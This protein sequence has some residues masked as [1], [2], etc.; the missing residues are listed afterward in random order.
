MN[1]LQTIWSVL[2]TPNMQMANY[3]SAPLILV[4]AYVTMLLFTSLLNIETN[5][6]KRLFYVLFISLI[7]LCLKFFIPSPYSTILN[8]ILIPIIIKLIFKTIFYFKY[9]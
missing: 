9:H 5:R 3:I 4:E 1:L 7:S 6:K 2:T 8:M